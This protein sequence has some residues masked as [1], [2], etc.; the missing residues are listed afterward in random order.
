MNKTYLPLFAGL[1]LADSSAHARA[2]KFIPD[3]IAVGAS[4]LVIVGKVT[5][6]KAV[7]RQGPKAPAGLGILSCKVAVSEVIFDRD[8]WEAAAKRKAPPPRKG[9]VLTV[10]IEDVGLR[11]FEP[12]IGAEYGLILKRMADGGER[13]VWSTHPAYRREAKPEAVAAL[14]RAADLDNWGW[15]KETNGLRLALVV[16]EILPYRAKEGQAVPVMMAVRNTS[17]DTVYL[18]CKDADEL[19]SARG[20]APDGNTV[21][22]RLRRDAGWK[23]SDQAAFR[24]LEPGRMGFITPYGARDEC[25]IFHLPL[26]AGKAKLQVI[27]ES[28]REGYVKED[29]RDKGGP[30]LWKGKISSAEVDIEL[31]TPKN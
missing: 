24:K 31:P 6:S 14:K 13:H 8:G 27:Y 16:G 29:P 26:P 22:V 11:S 5:D 30:D 17:K 21:T 2:Y 12:E 18:N 19:L 9:D 4:D 7:P 23:D 1:L 15:G 28:N 3:Q 10:V 25:H 20:V